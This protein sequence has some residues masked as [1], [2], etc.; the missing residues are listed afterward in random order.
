MY[1]YCEI[2][3]NTIIISSSFIVLVFLLQIHNIF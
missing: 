3:L 1:Y 2:K